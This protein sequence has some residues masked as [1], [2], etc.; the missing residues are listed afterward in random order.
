MD[1]LGEAGSPSPSRPV[2]AE[3]R[4]H[5]V[6]PTGYGETVNPVPDIVQHKCNPL[7]T[8][9]DESRLLGSR[10]LFAFESSTIDFATGNLIGVGTRWE[11]AGVYALL[12][13]S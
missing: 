8:V 4:S 13:Q 7:W 6:R 9:P 5:A 11:A 3:G 1:G 12:Y 10:G 2:P